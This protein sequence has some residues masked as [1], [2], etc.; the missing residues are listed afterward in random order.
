MKRPGRRLSGEAQRALSDALEQ[1]DRAAFVGLFAPDAQCTLPN[2]AQGPEAI[3]NL[4]LPFL[5]D[6]GTTML[7]TATTIA[8]A[9]S[10]EQGTTS[11]PSRS[12]A[13]R[14]P[15]S[16]RSPPASSPSRGGSST[17]TGR[18]TGSP[19]GRG[20]NARRR[21]TRAASGRLRFGMTREEVSRV[22][23]C[24][25]YTNVASTGGLEC[26]SYTFD[27]RTMNVSFIFNGNGLR[28][29]QLRDDEG[30]KR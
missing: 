25:P 28:R 26:P 22:T 5:I 15:A 14:R 19:G 4:W 20:T 18:L 12:G 11:V 3:A 16:R 7:L 30:E 24:E 2:A 8:P 6:P 23:A 29:V 13:A 27:G 10:G 9:E 17:V 21:R 1:H